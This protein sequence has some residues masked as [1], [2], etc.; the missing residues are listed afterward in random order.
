MG[1]TAKPTALK[2]LHGQTKPSQINADEPMPPAIP[3]DCPE[4]YTD[5]QRKVWDETWHDLSY[6][7]IIDRADAPSLRSYVEA[8]VAK[9]TA[10]RIMN[11]A[12]LLVRDP[13]TGAPKVN[14]AFNAWEKA[15]NLVSRGAREFGLAPAYRATMRKREVAPLEREDR[16]PD[17]KSLL[18]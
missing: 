13:V 15:A 4:V 6:M 2:M 1:R 14:P 5:E 9:D 7:G 3:P 8:V 16:P 18:A 11:Q 12:G 10:L 17:G